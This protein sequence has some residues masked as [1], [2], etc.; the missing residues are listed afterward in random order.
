V[1]SSRHRRSGGLAAPLAVA[2]ST[3]AAALVAVLA[4]GALQPGDGSPAPHQS[5][6]SKSPDLVMVEPA[7][8]SPGSP[9]STPRRTASR[10][11]RSG[12]ATASAA[13]TAGAVVRAGSRTRPGGPPTE[14]ASTAAASSGHPVHP[15]HPAHP[16]QAATSPSRPALPSQVTSLLTTKL[17]L[18]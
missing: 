11:V 9:A 3:G 15:T 5:S 18:P 4:V 1:S 8:G 7:S 12:S 10:A 13:T 2:T 6:A 16:T 14:P 17:P